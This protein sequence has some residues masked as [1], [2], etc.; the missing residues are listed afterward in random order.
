VTPGPRS[1]A[2]VGASLAGLSAARALRALGFDGSL[3]VVG[4]E[5][6]RPYDRPPLSKEFLAGKRDEADLALEAPG[7]DLAVDWRLG[8]RATRLS[9]NDRAVLL[10]DGSR[11]RIDAVVIATGARARALPGPPLAGVHLLRTLEDARA[12]RA[13]L[14][15]AHRLVVVGAGFV[16]AEVAATARGLGR[17]VT[18]VE[19]AATPLSGPLGVEMGA[20]V[21]ALHHDNG[22]RLRCGIPVAALTGTDRVDGV[23]LA[24]GTHLP[25]DVV[26]LGIGASPCVDWLAGSPV[27]VGDGVRCDASGGTGI[28]G[29]VAVG[30]CAAWYQPDLGHHRVEHWTAAATHPRIAMAALLGRPAVAPRAP[31]FWSDQYGLRIQFAGHA[32][33]GDEVT[34]EDGTTAGPGFLAVYRR[35]G[36]EV[37][38]LGVDR[39]RLFTQRRRA[40]EPARSTP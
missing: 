21:A 10:D 34:V 22:V 19:A 9:T 15:T 33:P 2:V 13:D 20:A 40:L 39:V 12:L 26:V 36:R 35:A 1:V 14:A 24:D 7:E 27:P 18:V 4:E 28:P 31:Y 23:R 6:H 29:V 25:A 11:V 38:V 5:A 37:A 8:R 16:G 17:S 32:R 3:M 30:D